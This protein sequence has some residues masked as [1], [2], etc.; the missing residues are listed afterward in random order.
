[1]KDVTSSADAV[2]K[3][4]TLGESRVRTDF[5]AAGTTIV[6]DIKR[7]GA[8]LIDLVNSIPVPEKM[9]ESPGEFLRVKA[10]ALTDLEYGA[11]MGVK[12]ATF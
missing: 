9:K 12:A 3:E 6:D 8:E 2:K 1:M 4:K 11:M 10:L 7:K 5:N